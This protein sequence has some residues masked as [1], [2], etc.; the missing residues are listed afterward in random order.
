MKLNIEILQR[1]FAMLYL[2]LELQQL[3]FNDLI[4]EGN[5]YILDKVATKIIEMQPQGKLADRY[6]DRYNNGNTYNIVSLFNEVK[7]YTDYEDL[8]GLIQFRDV[9][10]DD[11]S[12]DEQVEKYIR[13]FVPIVD[14]LY[15]LHEEKMKIFSEGFDV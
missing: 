3:I 9:F 12:I 5:Y 11:L 14:K 1:P 2:N 4:S 6:K 15:A 8:K 10:Y 13:V 7:R